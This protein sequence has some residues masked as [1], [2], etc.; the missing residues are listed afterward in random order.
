MTDE[1]SAENGAPAPGAP[2]DADRVREALRGVID[3][4]VGLDVVTMGLI[5]GVEV[6]DGRVRIRYALTTEGCPMADVIRNGIAHA[7]RRVPGVEDVETELVREPAWH[8]GM[9]EE[10][11]P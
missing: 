2:P 3:P 1:T 7:A 9:M 4:E 10:D 8:P 5:Y 6:E 11:A